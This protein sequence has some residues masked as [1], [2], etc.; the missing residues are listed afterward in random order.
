MF[1]T[2]VRASSVLRFAYFAASVTIIV[3]D[4]KLR[5]AKKSDEQNLILLQKIWVTMRVHCLRRV[6]AIVYS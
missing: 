1:E 6:T 2:R 3:A 5:S 4:A